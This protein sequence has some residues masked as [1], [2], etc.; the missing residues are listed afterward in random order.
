MKKVFS[1]LLIVAM[2]A[3][4][5]VATVSADEATTASVYGSHV[6]GKPGDTVTVTVA[7]S[8]ATDLMS[9]KIVL[10]YDATAL[11]AVNAS[12]NVTS[13]LRNPGRAVFTYAGATAI[14]GSATLF[15]VDFK[16]LADKCGSYPVSVSVDQFYGHG[17]TAL[18]YTVS[19]GSVSV[20]HDYKA[21][22]TV[23][24]TC[25]VKGYTKYEC[26]ICGDT[27]NE[28]ADL[29]DHTPKAAV[30]EN[31]V[32][33]TCT[34]AGSYDS[35]VYCSVCGEELSRET[36]NVP[37][38][39]HTYG[40]WKYNDEIHWHECS[41][42]GEHCEHEGEHDLYWK[43]MPGGKPATATE[44]GYAIFQCYCGYEWKMTLPANPDLDPDIPPTGDIT[45]AVTL[46][47]AA[48]LVTMMGAV[49]LVVKRKTVK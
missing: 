36:V 20:K 27:Y 34:T 17:T 1:I 22:E 32:E 40:D 19:G 8:N 28:Y 29:A 16:I 25:E 4:F 33:A 11:E 24:S 3:S 12:A 13:N 35:V 31:E 48:I 18:G 41:V 42:C 15:T 44:D 23:A 46:G 21:V 26:S 30:K 38:I 49:A 6:S 14:E 5:M 10:N 7:V 43:E 9:F 39:P 47:T 2:L 37:A 45:D